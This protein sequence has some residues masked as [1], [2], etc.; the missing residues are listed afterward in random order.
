MKANGYNRTQKNF[1]RKVL[2]MF[3]KENMKSSDKLYTLETSEWLFASEMPKQ[4]IIAF[5]NDKQEYAQMV[6]NKQKNASVEY[7]DINDTIFNSNSS[8]KF[9]GIYLDYC[10]SY[11]KNKKCVK[12]LFD[13]KKISKGC[14]LAMTFSIREGH[15]KRSVPLRKVIQA[16]LKRWSENNNYKIDF[17]FDKTYKDGSPMIT[18]MAKVI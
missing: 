16:D 13:K 9:K 10:G 15:I 5:Q 7:G 2:A 14:P 18:V 11:R 8:K 12:E 1:L 6:K 3:F 17:F 4:K